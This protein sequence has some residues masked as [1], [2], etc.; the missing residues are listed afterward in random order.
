MIPF[1]QVA[2]LPCI[3]ACKGEKLQQEG[4]RASPSTKPLNRFWDHSIAN[5]LGAVLTETLSHLCLQKQVLTLDLLFLLWKF[6]SICYCIKKQGT[7]RCTIVH[8]LEEQR[9]SYWKV[10]DTQVEDG[11]PTYEPQVEMNQIISVLKLWMWAEPKWLS[12]VTSSA[13]FL[14]TA[15]TL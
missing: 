15:G 1:F 13:L 6:R 14:E 11:W 12:S 4:K 9:E 5:R 2:W 3:L 10:I 8:V 7:G